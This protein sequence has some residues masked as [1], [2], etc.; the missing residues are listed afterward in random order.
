MKIVIFFFIV[1]AAI[2]IIGRMFHPDRSDDDT[3][4]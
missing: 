4:E 1:I 3:N 2:L